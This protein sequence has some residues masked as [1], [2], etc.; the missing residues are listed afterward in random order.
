MRQGSIIRVIFRD[1]RSLL[2]S[3]RVIL[4][5]LRIVLDVSSATDINHQSHFFVA[6]EVFGDVGG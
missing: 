1:R 2:C 6:G 4:V 3:W 5:A